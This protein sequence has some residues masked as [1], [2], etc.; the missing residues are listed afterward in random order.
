MRERY[1][2]SQ[3]SP[4][5]RLFLLLAVMVFGILAYSMSSV[6]PE[7][8]TQAQVVEKYPATNSSSVFDQIAMSLPYSRKLCI[9]TPERSFCSAVS[10]EAYT[11]VEVGQNVTVGIQNTRGD[12]YR[13]NWLRH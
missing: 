10:K 1:Y 6:G 7:K 5:L 12:G 13:I 9:Y 2:A 11:S 3:G 4:G 8:V